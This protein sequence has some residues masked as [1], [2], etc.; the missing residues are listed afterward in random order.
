MKTKYG[1][2]HA[3][4]GAIK[5][6]S[7]CIP[8]KLTTEATKALDE[9]ITMEELRSAVRA[10]KNGK[11]PERDGIGYDFNKLQWNTIKHELLLIIR[12]MHTERSISAQRKH[13]ILVCLPKTMPER[14][15]D[16]RALTLLNV[17]LK[18]LARILAK[19]ISVWAPDIMHMSQQV[20]LLG[21]PYSM[22]T[23]QSET[24]SLKW[25]R[26]M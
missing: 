19:R 4:S 3:N 18:I 21:R 11:A 6:M 15:D 20:E 10:G 25:K 26:V 17:D 16:Y 9:P 8:L 1:N 2:T 24:R 22:P 12:Q 7:T 13:G 5:R 14:P 23:Q